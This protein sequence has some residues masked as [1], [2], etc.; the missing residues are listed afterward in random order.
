[1]ER[2]KNN[3]EKGE[4]ELVELRGTIEICPLCGTDL[5]GEHEHG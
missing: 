3:I 5:K 4:K 1:M 2:T